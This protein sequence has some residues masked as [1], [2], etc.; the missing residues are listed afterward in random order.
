MSLTYIVQNDSKKRGGREYISGYLCYWR[1]NRYVSI[2]YWRDN[3]LYQ[4]DNKIWDN[5]RDRG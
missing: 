3:R 4:Y 2:R 1:D 5:I